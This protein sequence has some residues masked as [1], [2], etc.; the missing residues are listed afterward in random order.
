[1]ALGQEV[2]SQAVANLACI[3]AVVL[4]LGC[5]DRPQHQR[6]RHLHSRCMGQQVI[7]DPA[8]EHRR[9][10]GHGPRCWQGLHP[11]VELNPGRRNGAFRM[12]LAAY[13]LHAIA[14]RLLVD[15]QPDEVH[16]GHEEPPWMS[17]NQRITT[18]F[19]PCIPSAPHFRDLSIQTTR[20]CEASS[21][22]GECWKGTPQRHKCGST[23]YTQHKWGLWIKRL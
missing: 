17:L 13:V 15:V 11:L 5:R 3:D 7:V 12:H 2:A 21:D 4:L 20:P 18:E 16:T 10:H 1:M 6:M 23:P 22:S 8:C 19:S 9:F 14:D